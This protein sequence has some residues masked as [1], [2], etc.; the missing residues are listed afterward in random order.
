MNSSRE[1]DSWWSLA[2]DLAAARVLTWV[3]TVGKDASLTP[4]AHLY[5]FDRYRRL[6]RYHRERGRRARAA[7]LEERADQHHRAA[8]GTPPPYAAAMAMPRPPRWIVTDAVSRVRLNGHG[9]DAA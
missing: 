2:A 4:E 3:A 6:A 1:T 5:F 9:D 7:R 8:G